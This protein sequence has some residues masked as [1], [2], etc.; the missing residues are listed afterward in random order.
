MAGVPVLIAENATRSAPSLD[1]YRD[2]CGYARSINSK[3]S[4]GLNPCRFVLVEDGTKVFAGHFDANRPALELDL[5]D[6]APGT[7]ATS[8]LASFCGIA[9]L[10]AH[11]RTYLGKLKIERGIRPFAS[12]GGQPLLLSKRALNSF[13]AALSPVLRRYFSSNVQEN[14]REIA[15]KAYVSSAEITEY[16]RVL[17]ALLKDRVSPRRDSIVE[18]IRTSRHDEPRLTKAIRDYSGAEQKGGQLQIIQGGVGSG[19]SLFARRYRDLLEPEEMKGSNFWAF[20]DFGASPPSL[21]EAERWFCQSFVESFERENPSIG[22]YDPDVQKGIFSRK[23]QQRRGYYETLRTASHEDEIRARATDLATWQADPIAL[24][25]GI[26]EYISGIKQKNLVVVMDNV[27][28][29]D[30]QTQLDAF[31]L[32]LWFMDRSKAFVILQMRDETYERYKN[33]RPLDT[34]RSGIA[35]HIAPPRFIDVVKR[36]LDL[37]VE[38]LA[39]HAGSTQEYMLDNGARVILPKGE[40]GNFL[41]TIYVLLFAHRTNVARVLESL[42]GR[43][44][45]KALEMFAAIVTSGHISTSAITSNVRGQGE[46]PINEYHIIRILMRTE[47]RF[48]SE[49]S[50]YICNIF[51]YD[52]DWNRPDNFLLIEIL[53]F[54]AR[55]LKRAGDIGLE[56]Y[57]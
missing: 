49:Q 3:Y 54:L 19:K 52:N 21:K 43:D 7:V 8:N 57:F 11:A 50:G 20:V 39:A 40:F 36:R 2:L 22:I 15:E 9:V 12:A 29:L 5:V 4:G 35:F 28:K 37:A 1:R 38:Y 47:Y 56:G 33:R 42:A 23:I 26:A 41:R 17:E 45:R 6:I 18:P 24:A 44:T 46:F 51:Y 48:F 31:Q 30:L 10:E 34:F 13:A 55:R 53:F 16:D 25:E 27:D 32:S 14:I